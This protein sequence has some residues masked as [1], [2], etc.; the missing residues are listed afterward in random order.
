MPRCALYLDGYFWQIM[1]SSLYIF[2]D[3]EGYYIISFWVCGIVNYT[4]AKQSLFRIMIMQ[5]GEFKNKK[6]MQ[7]DGFF[8]SLDVP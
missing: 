4:K 3:P 8:G 7:L 5:F 6:V 2:R 1:A